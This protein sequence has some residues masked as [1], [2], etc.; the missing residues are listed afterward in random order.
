V[1][2]AP[3]NRQYSRFIVAPDVWP[4]TREACEDK[5]ATQR[6]VADATAAAADT[7]RT[8]LNGLRAEG[9]AQSIGFEAMH[10]AYWRVQV[11]ADAKAETD[12]AAVDLMSNIVAIQHGAE[13]RI[14]AIDADAHNQLA[15]VPSR[16]PLAV[17]IITSAAA[18][19]R[20]TAV[21]AADEI[22]A[23]S[24]QFG[25]R[26]GPIPE[27]PA[28]SD[29]GTSDDSDRS[30]DK[31]TDETPEQPHNG[32]SAE[33][34]GTQHRTS[35]PEA[36]EAVSGNTVPRVSPGQPLPPPSSPYAPSPPTT[37]RSPA[38]A[39]GGIGGGGGGIG[40]ASS[41]PSTGSSGGLGGLGSGFLGSASG[42]VSSA[43]SAGSATSPASTSPVAAFSRGLPVVP[44]ASFTSGAVV[45]SSSAPAAAPPVSAP[46]A[47]LLA[48]PGGG[49]HAAVAAAPG[50]VPPQSV[51]GPA[52]PVSAAPLLPPGPMG[53]PP[54]AA[55]TA[56]PA[57]GTGAPLAPAGPMGPASA[58][59][60]AAAAV[61]T[62]VATL[63]SRVAAAA[64]RD[65]E[66]QRNES[67]DL[68][69]VRRLAWELLHASQ[70]GQIFALWSVG[71][72]YSAEGERQVVAVS[73]LGAGYVPA[74]VTVPGF[75]RM[76]WS[77]PLI[78]DSFRQR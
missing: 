38:A 28:S 61:A 36:P 5:A 24:G 78:D 21:G 43:G 30:S 16:S 29:P 19:A 53:P 37:G 51:S 20:R 12:S 22:T 32:A 15:Y 55:F 74:G 58:S 27:S 56:S 31:R 65:F 2:A 9:V 10:Q 50:V 44:P 11:E 45:S 13:Q 68:Q 59:V 52:Q 64:A 1:G 41:L 8:A 7:H 67:G 71:V 75:V 72:M 66:R 33:S 54:A 14:D 77:D 4:T 63:P 73:H 60:T 18:M 3:P 17:G 40:G 6:R 42:G 49:S 34:G 23:L 46:A 39:L 47:P 26:F 62:P 76:L 48:G 25:Q 70:S 57:G 69:L 35:T